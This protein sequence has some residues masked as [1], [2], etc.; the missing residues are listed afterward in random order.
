VREFEYRHG[1]PG[2][3]SNR[4]LI[5]GGGGTQEKKRPASRTQR[6][7]A[8]LRNYGGERLPESHRVYVKI[9]TITMGDRGDRNIKGGAQNPHRLRESKRRKNCWWQKY[10]VVHVPFSAL[11]GNLGTA[12]LDQKIEAG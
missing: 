4:H 8:G 3:I 11:F 7:H 1:P 6:G 5:G 10:T 9:V 12:A 2:G